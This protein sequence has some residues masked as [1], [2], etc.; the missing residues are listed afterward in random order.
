MSDDQSIYDLEK[1]LE[2]MNKDIDSLL[3]KFAKSVS[4]ESLLLNNSPPR[5][6]RRRKKKNLPQA[7]RVQIRRSQNAT[8]GVLLSVFSKKKRAVGFKTKNS[9]LYPIR[10]TEKLSEFE[11]C[12]NSFNIKRC[13]HLTSYVVSPFEDMYIV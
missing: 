9:A 11:Y 5:N 2:A 7:K 12:R 1:Q 10:N 4:D 3:P 13:V 6:R 8:P